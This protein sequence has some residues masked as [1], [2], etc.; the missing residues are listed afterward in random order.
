MTGKSNSLSQLIPYDEP[1]IT[2]GDASQSKTLGKSK[3]IHG[4]I[5]IEDILLA[6]NLKYNLISI[7][8]LC[9]HNYSIEFHRHMC[10]VKNSFGNII[11]TGDR[12]GNA[13]KVS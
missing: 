6:E 8:Q 10:T 4:N 7:S 9:D 1:K 13:Y 11:M 2:F 5:I 3:L 12:C